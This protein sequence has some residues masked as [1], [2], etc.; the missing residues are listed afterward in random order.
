MGGKQKRKRLVPVVG[1]LIAVVLIAGYTYLNAEYSADETALAALET[2]AGVTVTMPTEDLVVFAAK[3]PR[4][5]LVFYPGGKVEHLAYAPL[6]RALAQNG[7]TCILTE[8]P[9]NLA[10]LN[11]DAAEKARE[12][13]PELD[14]WYI[15][16]HSLGGAMAAAHAYGKADEYEGLVLLAAYSTKDL[17]NSDMKVISLYATE[18]AVLD[19]DKYMECRLNLPADT[20]EQVMEGGNHAMFGSYGPQKGDGTATVSPEEQINWAVEIISREITD[21]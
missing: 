19:M 1:M 10:V 2:G 15:G 6:L 11:M 14:C 13:L 21:K 7:I 9:F 5:G 8:M 4:A 3:E 20:I 18:D 16:G 12:Q 17:S